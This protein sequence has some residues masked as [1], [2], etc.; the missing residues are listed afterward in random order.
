VAGQAKVLAELPPALRTA[1][2]E[3]RLRFHVDLAG[4]FEGRSRPPA[5]ETV[6]RAVWADR[7]LRFR[8][9]RDKVERDR[10][11]HPLGIVVKAGLWY[12]VG[13]VDDDRR[14]YRVDRIRR[15][16]VTD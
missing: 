10:V 6:A 11:T 1:A 5:L 8:Y 9:Q 14:V 4:W 12:L 13:G 3:S 7:R 15:P 16:V 2:S